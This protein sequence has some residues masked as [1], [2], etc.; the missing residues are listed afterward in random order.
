[1]AEVMMSVR[2]PDRKYKTYVWEAEE[3]DIGGDLKLTRYTTTFPSG[4]RVVYELN[5]KEGY[6]AITLQV[7]SALLHFAKDKENNNA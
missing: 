5:D 7:F 6:M 1:M 4:P 2:E 3:W